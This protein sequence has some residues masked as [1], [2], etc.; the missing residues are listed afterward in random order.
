VLTRTTWSSK[1]NSLYVS[2]VEHSNCSSG[3]LA[4]CLYIKLQGSHHLG[5]LLLLISRF[6]KKIFYR[7]ILKDDDSCNHA[8][9]LWFVMIHWGDEHGKVVLDY[10]SITPFCYALTWSLYLG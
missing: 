4:W 5:S 9:N 8:R 10:G 6:E 7:D 3:N 1:P 2:L